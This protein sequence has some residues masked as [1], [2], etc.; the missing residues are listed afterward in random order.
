MNKMSYADTSDGKTKFGTSF[1][2][3]SS[4]RT[5]VH[6]RVGMSWLD[7]LIVKLSSV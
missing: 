2:N 3:R 5:R 4:L 7:R 6:V 1:V